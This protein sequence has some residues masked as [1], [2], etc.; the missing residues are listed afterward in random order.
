MESVVVYLGLAGVMLGALS[1]LK[2]LRWLGIRTRA[3]GAALLLTGTGV[4][5]IGWALPTPERHG[6]ADGSRLDGV[7]PVYQFVERHETRI[8]ADPERVYAAV[9]GVTAG[10][11]QLFRVLTWIRSPRWPWGRTRETILSAPAGEPILEVA[12]RSGF[13]LLAEE[14]NREIVFGS[15]VCCG[16]ARATSAAEF[17]ALELPGVAKA[18]MNFRLTQEADGWTQ[19]STETRVFATDPAACRRFAAY[20]R[21]I[22]PGSALIR[23][24]WLRAIRLR[25]EAQPADA[26][27]S[28]R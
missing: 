21:V 17:A 10:E 28:R 22:Y 1:L 18:V 2:P 24:M 7:V 23:R 14:T 11:I 16:G 3:H 12:L 9:K 6:P 19:L 26:H 27:R 5:A 13:V 25:A 20:W 8:H 15:V 4:V